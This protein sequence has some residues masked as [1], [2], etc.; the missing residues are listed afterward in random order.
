M[1]IQIAWVEWADGLC[2]V[3]LLQVQS[4]IIDSII[5]YTYK[6]ALR[7][8]KEKR[9]EGLCVLLHFLS[10]FVHFFL[11]WSTA[12][13]QTFYKHT[14]IHT[15]RS[16]GLV[17]FMELRE[18]KKKSRYINKLSDYILCAYSFNA[19]YTGGRNREREETA[20]SSSR[21]GRWKHNKK[22]QGWGRRTTRCVERSRFYHFSTREQKNW[23]SSLV[24]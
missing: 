20:T 6:K 3:G 18:K 22:T 15:H 9:G 21:G 4:T 14:H 7:K 17:F 1:S 11:R 19:V 2:V 16:R 8:T 5:K 13:R 23:F 24:S 10:L 12:G